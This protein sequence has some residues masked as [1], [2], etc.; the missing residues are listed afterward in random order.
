MAPTY[1]PEAPFRV[2]R[3]ENQANLF[4]SL[5]GSV[6]FETLGKGRQGSV[7]IKP[8]E[9]GGIPIVRTTTV[10]SAPAQLFSLEHE[11]L[12]QQI[13]ERALLPMGFNNALIETYTHAYT[14]MG[15]HSDL[16]LDLAEGSF[17]AL[18]SC[19]KYP[20][21]TSSPRK[22]LIESKQ[23]GGKK[24]E[25]V[26]A[27]NSF[28]LFSVECNRH[29]RHK[30]VLET[31]SPKSDNPWLGITFRCS[32]TFLHFRD[33]VAYFADNTPLTLAN[34]EELSAFYPMRR[35]ENQE[36]DFRYPDL[37]YTLS[38][39]DMMPPESYESPC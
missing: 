8:S 35:R 29:Y 31:A 22:L 24:S 18:F 38:A 6:R 28:V 19:Y 17:I 36:M 15:S 16:A 34:Q 23:P 21:L 7:L 25:I 39:S 13:Q 12:A 32:K 27:H 5:Y 26:L 14:H 11:R 33:Q 10:Y 20:E 1:A 9:S 2:Y 37:T 4:D 30:I 3:L